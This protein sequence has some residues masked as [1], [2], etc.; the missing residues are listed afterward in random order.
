MKT[1]LTHLRNKQLQFQDR[2]NVGDTTSTK[3][4]LSSHMP[5]R[6]R[7]SSWNILA[8][9]AELS[10]LLE[11]TN[12]KHHKKTR[13]EYTPDRLKEMHIELIDILH[14]WMN[15]CIIWDLSPEDIIK[16]YDEKND[17]N[18]NRQEKGY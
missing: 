12:W 17:E 6:E 9:H 10:E 3:L 11:W 8:M 5:D 14:Y 16:I 2:I 13:V 7:M 1:F 18:H 15:L 4:M